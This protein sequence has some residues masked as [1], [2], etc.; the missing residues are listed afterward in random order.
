MV[1][2]MEVAPGV[3][4]GVKTILVERGLWT[5]AVVGAKAREE[6]EYAAKGTER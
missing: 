5:A 3:N 4:K 1:Q 2:V 6:R